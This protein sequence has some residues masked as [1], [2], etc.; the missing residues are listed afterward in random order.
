[1]ASIAITN[2]GQR[3][4]AGDLDVESASFKVM[5]CTSSY[6][7]DKDHDFRN[8]ITNEVTGTGYTAGGEDCTVTLEATDTT[9]DRVKITLGGVTWDT[10]TITA[11]YAVYYAARGG[12][13]SAD[14]VIACIDFGSNVISTAGDFTLEDSEYRW[15]Y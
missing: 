2:T 11:R 3:M 14:E 7:P 5:L 12:A 1:M 4:L 10:A 8:D 6:T 15:Q 13:S 9:N